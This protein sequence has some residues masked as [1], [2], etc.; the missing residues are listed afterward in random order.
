MILDEQAQQTLRKRAYEVID[1]VK[2]NPVTGRKF[3]HR[4]RQGVTLMYDTL[5]ALAWKKSTNIYSPKYG[6]EIQYR[7][8]DVRQPWSEI[9][10]HAAERAH[11]DGLSNMNA[12]RHCKLL[13]A[14]GLI[15]I[16]HEFVRSSKSM[17]RE[18][19]TIAAPHALRRSYGGARTFKVIRLSLVALSE[20]Q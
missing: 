7:A 1:R 14:L 17:K 13:V 16:E 10:R 11:R 15:S 2:T 4:L 18:P 9:S 3:T 5:L 8:G 12:Q 6:R 19:L 20:N